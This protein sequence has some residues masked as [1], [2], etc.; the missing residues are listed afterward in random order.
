MWT[1]FLFYVTM[2]KREN[3][4]KEKISKREIVFMTISV[5]LSI[6]LIALSFLFLLKKEKQDLFKS[7]YDQKCESYRV[8]NANLSKNQIV[9]IGDSITDFYQLDTY[10]ADLNKATYNRGIGG[11]TCQGVLNRMQVSLYDLQPS[12]IVLMIGI[13]DING[14]RTKEY[15]VSKY[16]EI[17]SN[18]KT[19]LPTTEV[20]CMS[21]ISMNPVIFLYPTIE[22]NIQIVKSVNIELEELAVEKGYTYLDLFTL[23]KDENEYLKANYTDDGIH[24]NAAGFSVWSGL[25]KPYLI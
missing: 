11:D 24:L 9:F 7:Y 1:T 13:N 3:Y 20:Y 22:S 18:I 12:K 8:Q 15:I 23:T 19:N 21:I 10:Y 17:L 6:V 4:M 25:V 2:T 16:D 14:G 5:L